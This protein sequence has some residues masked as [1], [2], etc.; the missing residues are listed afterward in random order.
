MVEFRSA[1]VDELGE[2][3]YW[4]SDLTKAEIDEIMS[5]HEEWMIKCVNW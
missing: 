1:I 4:L 5:N 3:M 2:V